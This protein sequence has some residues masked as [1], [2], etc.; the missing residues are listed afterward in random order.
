MWRCDNNVF[1]AHALDKRGVTLHHIAQRLDNRKV[2]AKLYL[3]VNT[4]LERTKHLATLVIQSLDV[5]LIC[6][7]THLTQAS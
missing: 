5:L 6:Q 3:I 7:E 4:L 2:L 1:I